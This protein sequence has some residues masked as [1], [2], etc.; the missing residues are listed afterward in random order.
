MAT[1]TFTPISSNID[2]VEWDSET[3]AM[4]V[5]FLRNGATYTVQNVTPEEWRRFQMAPSAGSFFIANFKNR[6]S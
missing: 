4:D 2:T 3:G 6:A 5:T 1:E